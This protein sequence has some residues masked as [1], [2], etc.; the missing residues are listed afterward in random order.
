LSYN[1]NVYKL[2]KNGRRAKAPF[3]VFEYDDPE[4]VGDYFNAEV[5]ENFTEKIRRSKLM[6]LR[7]DLPQ[8][9]KINMG[10]D[11]AL[12]K[13]NQSRVFR[14]LIKNLGPRAD[15][16]VRRV[17]GGL[18]FCKETSWQWQWAALEL[19]TSQY[20]KGLS[21]LFESYDD[22][23]GWMLAEIDKLL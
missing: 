19:G 5:K 18:I 10:D 3:H 17:T 22:A 1:W 16:D 15:F 2:F 4:S 8:D 6:V 23:H 9:Q 14:N 7:S 11:Q 13:Q 21:P 12:I 20:V